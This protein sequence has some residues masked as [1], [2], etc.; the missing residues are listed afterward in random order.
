VGELEIESGAMVVYGPPPDDSDDPPSG[1]VDIELRDEM[2]SPLESSCVVQHA[3]GRLEEVRLQKGVLRVLAKEAEGLKI[4]LP[5]LDDARF[6][7]SELEFAGKGSPPEAEVVLTHRGLKAGAQAQLAF[8]RIDDD[9]DGGASDPHPLGEI[10]VALT[11][12]DTKL[13]SPQETR[14]RWPLTGID[15]LDAGNFCTVLCR[16]TA[17]ELT[18]DAGHLEVRGPPADDEGDD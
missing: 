13:A 1:D 15:P 5:Q 4:H 12:D 9:D 8:F 7:E 6:A 11:G 18:M 10:T 16:V 2:G 3:D 17:G 14:A